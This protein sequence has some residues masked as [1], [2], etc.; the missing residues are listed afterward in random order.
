MDTI[1]NIHSVQV[2]QSQFK[3]CRAQL[4][5]YLQKFRTRLKGKNRV[6]IAQLV[7]L[8]DSVSGYL[9]TKIR[10][11]AVDGIVD[12]S[13][14]MAGQGVDQINLHKL[15]IYLQESK[16]ARK[17][18]A[19]SIHATKQ[20]ANISCKTQSYPS[21]PTMPVLSHIQAFFQSLMGSAAEG[22]FFFEKDQNDEC[23]L[24]YMLL[25]P[26]FHFKAVV[27]DA[28]AIILAGGTMSPVYRIVIQPQALRLT[29]I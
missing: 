6:Y 15:V 8:I 12:V 24:K 23:F 5:I 9:D 19:Y 3:H 13:D 2:N 22:R 17:I 20:E 11:K 26:T 1:S 10:E 7:R 27:E 25:D 16:L 18:E 4:N 29:P 14:L 21:F 28:R